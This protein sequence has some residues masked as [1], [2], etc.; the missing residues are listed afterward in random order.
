M[1]QTR[2][3]NQDQ[4]LTTEQ[5]SKYRGTA[6]IRLEFLHFLCDG[7]L[8]LNLKT[9]KKL[10]NSFRTEGCHRLELINHI[11][12]VINKYQLNNTL[13]ASGL[14]ANIIKSRL[15]RGFW[16]RGTYDS[17]NKLKTALIEEYSNGKSPSDREI[18]YR[19]RLYD[20][21]ESL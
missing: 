5:W 12:A 13:Q 18:Y 2:L 19:I 21:E 6:C 20:Q 15:P 9:V 17:S 10:K 16:L 7:S 4:R 8:E 11:P 1:L 14:M 3:L